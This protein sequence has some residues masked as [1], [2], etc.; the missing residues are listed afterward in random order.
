MFFI[1]ITNI[2]LGASAVVTAIFTPLLAIGYITSTILIAMQKKVG[3]YVLF[4]TLGVSFLYMMFSVI[5]SG[6]F[7]LNAGMAISSI[8]TS[9]VGHGLIA[10]YFITSKRVKATITK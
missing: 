10:L 3:I 1:A 4:G 9:F 7:E 5:V 8:L 6:L 2:S